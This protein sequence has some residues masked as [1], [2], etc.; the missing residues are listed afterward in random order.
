MRE[1][2]CVTMDITTACNRHCDN[3]CAG[4]HRR[5]V[6]HHPWEYFVQAAEH[7]YGIYRL[8]L[9]GGEPTMHPS[10]E[11]L[12]W[13]LRDLFGCK[14]LTLSTNGFKVR[15]YERE[16][17]N[18][19]EIYFSDYGENHAELEWLQGHYGGRII[20]YCQEFTPLDRR[21][22]GQPCHRGLSE[23]VAHAHGR[24]FPCCVGPGIPGAESLE[25]C[26]GWQKKVQAV[27]LPCKDCWFSP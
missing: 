5:P 1:I 17:C 23:T 6:V 4:M 24:L 16:L 11:F 15:Q 14:L 20:H 13:V 7:L 2:N 27:P 8:N 22:S 12:A 10:F 25:P 26:A 21:G 3:C 9:T 19:D 18:F